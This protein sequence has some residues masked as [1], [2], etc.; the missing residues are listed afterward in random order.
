MRHIF[1]KLHNIIKFFIFNYLI[2]N[3]VQNYTILFEFLLFSICF[4]TCF[5]N[6]LP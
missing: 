3:N 2:V 4:I 6:N 5:T 1:I